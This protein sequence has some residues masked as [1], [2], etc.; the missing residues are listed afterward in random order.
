MTI[1]LL[2]L[3]SELYERLA[4]EAKELGDSVQVV[5][6]RTLEGRFGL[7]PSSERERGREAL[8][9]S[10]MLT[11]LG[12]EMTERA[13]RSAVS[14]EETQVAFD[15]SEGKPLSEIVLEMRG[16]KG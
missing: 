9:L 11:E 12:P 16:P 6:R 3:P 7:T 13:E 10:G 5:A 4:Q 2:E 8:Q 1:L 14:L 15:N